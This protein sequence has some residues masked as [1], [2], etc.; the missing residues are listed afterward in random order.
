MARTHDRSGRRT[1]LFGQA[2]RMI[3]S[4]R[5]GSTG[6][7]PTTRHRC[8][9]SQH[10]CCRFLSPGF[11][12]SCLHR[13]SVLWGDHITACYH[14]YRDVMDLGD[15]R[16]WVEATLEGDV[17]PS[18]RGRSVSRRP[19]RLLAEPAGPECPPDSRVI[20][21]APT[22]GVP[23]TQYRNPTASHVFHAMAGTG[24]APG[25]RRGVQRSAS[26]AQGAAI[27]MNCRGTPPRLNN[28]PD[29]RCQSDSPGTFH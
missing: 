29:L 24:A 4:C 11:L 18:R 20:S 10:L 23:G 25:L 19:D 8:L 6:F 16:A 3:V 14:R 27:S 9:G 7:S 22:P 28:A 15:A 5:P 26:S 12:R 2:A 21:E 13:S 1:Q 17:T